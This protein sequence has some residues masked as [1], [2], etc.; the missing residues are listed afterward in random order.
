MFFL[1]TT[2]VW[3]TCFICKRIENFHRQKKTCERDSGKQLVVLHANTSNTQGPWWS[4]CQLRKSWNLRSWF[5]N[6]D[7]LKVNRCRI[8]LA[9][10][11]DGVLPKSFLYR[12]D[13][14][15]PN[16]ESTNAPYTHVAKKWHV[17][18][19]GDYWALRRQYFAKAAICFDWSLCWREKFL[20]DGSG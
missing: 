1:G 17:I 12:C 4:T 11:L 2:S 9:T 3:W 19:R 6:M 8:N 7:V 10:L 15:P 16:T 5:A 18:M 13:R 14:M 20:R